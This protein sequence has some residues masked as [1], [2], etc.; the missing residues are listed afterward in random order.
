MIEFENVSRIYKSGEHEL[1][2]LDNLSLTI[3]KGEFVVILGPSGAGKST[4]LNLL[5][6]LDSATSGKIIVDGE[7]IV[8]YDDDQ[9]TKYRAKSVGFIFQFYN[10]IPNLTAKENVELMKDITD[11]EI[12]VNIN[13]DEILNSVGLSGHGDQFPAQLSGGEQQ[14]VSI[15]RALAKEPAMLLCDEPTGA[16]DSNTGVLILSLLQNMCHEKDTTVVIVTHNS[17][18]ADAADKLIRIKNGKI[19]SVTI[20]ENPMDVNLIEW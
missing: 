13:G 10:L 16:L 4:L 20:N 7:N 17:K 5:G 2:A 12:D 9:L 8:D 11:V 14:R 18:L 19:E 3:D 15:A 1:K 6:G